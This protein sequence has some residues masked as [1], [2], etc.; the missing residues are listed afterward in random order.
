MHELELDRGRRLREGFSSL[1]EHLGTFPG[2]NTRRLERN[3]W[4]KTSGK[5]HE[6]FSIRDTEYRGFLSTDNYSVVH[7]L[8]VPLSSFNPAPKLASRHSLSRHPGRTSR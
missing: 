5:E 4:Q 2:R 7:T 8:I 3:H 1:D 6:S